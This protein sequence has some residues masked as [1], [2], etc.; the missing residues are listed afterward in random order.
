MSTL[1]DFFLDNK[2]SELNGKMKTAYCCG[3]VQ[4]DADTDYCILRCATH[5]KD[6]F[7]RLKEAYLACEGFTNKINFSSVM[8]L[9]KV[10]PLVVIISHPH[11]QPKQVSVGEATHFEADYIRWGKLTYNA[12]TC[13]GSSGAPVI[14][15]SKKRRKMMNVGFHGT[16]SA[17]G[18]PYNTGYWMRHHYYDV[19]DLY[20]A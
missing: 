3:V 14:L 9:E 20:V 1:V 17:G 7:H 2:Y 10:D 11:G 16:H 5:D 6:L 12:S 18:E 8:M 19:F 15:T 13:P 4:S